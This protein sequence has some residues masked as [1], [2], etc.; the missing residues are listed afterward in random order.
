[1]KEWVVLR[2]HKKEVCC[3]FFLFSAC[4][5]LMPLHTNS[6]SMAPRAPDPRLRWLRRCDPPLGPLL[7]D[8]S[9]TNPN[10]L[11]RFI[12]HRNR[13]HLT[14]ITRHI[15]EHGRAFGARPANTPARDALP[16]ARLKRLGPDIS[17]SRTSPRLR[18]E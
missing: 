15:P 7:P 1:M 13:F 8:S 3:V 10:I 5:D 14:G 9:H 6:P 2:G 16:S 17:P 12:L 11:N 18:L 4:Q